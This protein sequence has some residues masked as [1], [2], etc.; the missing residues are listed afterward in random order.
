M[1]TTNQASAPFID[2]EQ[3]KNIRLSIQFALNGFSFALQDGL[4]GRI[5]KIES[6]EVPLMLGDEA[7]FQNE[8]VQLR[9]ENFL[10]QNPFDSYVFDRVSVV[11]TNSFFTLIPQ[12]LYQ[13][14]VAPSYLSIG[15]ELPEDFT[16]KANYSREIDAYVVYGIYAP[17]FFLLS[18]TFSNLEIRHE[19][20]VFLNKIASIQKK[21]NKTAVYVEAHADSFLVS[22]FQA[23]KL[24]L[25][26]TFSFKEKEDFVYFLLAI[27][28]LLQLNV[29][30][31]P[32]W[33]SGMI[34]R[35]SPLYAIA[36][37]YIRNIDFV[38]IETADL[39]FD[40]AIED[41]EK[42]KFNLLTQALVCE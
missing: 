8:K 20:T 38:K 5:L 3:I 9:F 31:I 42:M 15:H 32:L 33:F 28:D 36:Y 18:D 6:I 26:N 16:V 27:Y 23:E 19:L 34:D 17:L 35:R 37:Q 13:E 10:A 25:A 39:I 41:I 29:E 1:P 40:P 21:E 12:S 2:R 7:A 11:I 30:F 22:V 4:S 24:L 14:E